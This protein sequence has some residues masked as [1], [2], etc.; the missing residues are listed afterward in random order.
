MSA[1]AEVIEGVGATLLLTQGEHVGPC[2]GRMI[3]TG[4]YGGLPGVGIYD[5]ASRRMVLIKGE[6][7]VDIAD[8]ITAEWQAAG[9]V[10]ARFQQPTPPDRL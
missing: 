8:G 6:A 1:E 10:A 2:G 9:K 5:H 3:V 7:L 4:M